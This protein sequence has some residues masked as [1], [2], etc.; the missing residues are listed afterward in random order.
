[1]PGWHVFSLSEITRTLPFGEVPGQE[2][3]TLNEVLTSLSENFHF[4][5]LN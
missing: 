1:M 4:S 3:R 5:S 2:V